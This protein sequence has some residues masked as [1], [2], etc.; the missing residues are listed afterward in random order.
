MK[1]GTQ[2]PIL[3]DEHRDGTIWGDIQGDIWVPCYPE[4]WVVMSR[5]PFYIGQQWTPHCT[6][7][8]GPYT[9]VNN[10]AVQ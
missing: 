5:Q 1:L 2:V 6:P 3:T 4:G 9:A 10:A 8:Y 7:L